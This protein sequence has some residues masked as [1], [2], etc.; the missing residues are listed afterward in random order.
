MA[1]NELL[2]AFCSAQEC[3]PLHPGSSLGGISFKT[4]ICQAIIPSL[5][6]C[7]YLQS[8]Y[9][10]HLLLLPASASLLFLSPLSHKPLP[11]NGSVCHSYNHIT[12]YSGIFAQYSDSPAAEFDG[13]SSGFPRGADPECDM[14]KRDQNDRK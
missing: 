7:L 12:C 13:G 9:M 6:P 1:L 2:G 5:F 3:I 10:S 8:Y 11:L 4:I 14:F